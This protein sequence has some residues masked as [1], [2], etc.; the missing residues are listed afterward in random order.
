MKCSARPC[1]RCPKKTPGYRFPRF[2]R[3]LRQRLLAVP[4]AGGAYRRCSFCLWAQ[5]LVARR[6]YRAG[7]PGPNTDTPE[8]VSVIFFAHEAFPHGCNRNASDPRYAAENALKCDLI[9]TVT[10][11][12]YERSSKRAAELNA[13]FRQLS[14]IR[15]D[16]NEK[17]QRTDNA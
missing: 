17:S 9:S 12:G 1:L 15:P 6:A 11:P 10:I 16:R 14:A 8:G 3:P 2:S 5:T 13:S 7:P 4:A